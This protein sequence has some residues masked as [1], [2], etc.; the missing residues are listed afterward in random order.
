MTPSSDTTTH[1]TI[2]AKFSA[3]SELLANPDWE[4]AQVVPI[5]HD[6][7]GREAQR[8]QYAEAQLLWTDQWLGVRFVCRQA[9]APLVNAEPRLDQKT[10]G[11]WDKDVC[12]VFLAP[13]PNQPERYFEFEAAPT[14]EWVDLGIRV[15]GAGRETD[16]DYHSGMS[17][18]TKLAKQQ[19][20]IGMRIPWS[21]SLRKPRAGDTW[22]LN[23][24]R[25]VGTGNERYLAWQP[26]YAPEPYFHVPEVFG[27]LKFE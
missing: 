16:W 27:W 15:T 12:E 23:L 22:R 21:E 7:A 18:E 25:C 13:D 2:A 20:I 8:D 19:I 1:R 5:D 24:F 4:T 26:T 10:I 17:V 9:G 14:G 6:W 11:L 3:A